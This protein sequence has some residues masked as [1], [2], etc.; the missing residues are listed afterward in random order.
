[1]ATATS[2]RLLAAAALV[3]MLALA[4]CGG[5]ARHDGGHAGG[6][7]ARFAWL[8]PAAAPAD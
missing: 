4:G 5:A 3:A 7:P 6:A 2:S 1:M 8:R